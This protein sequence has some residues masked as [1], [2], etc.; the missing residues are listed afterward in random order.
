MTTTPR[1]LLATALTTAALAA[2]VDAPQTVPERSRY[3]ETSRAADVERFVD[4]CLALPHG[5]RLTVEK[6]RDLW[7]IETQ[8]AVDA[9]AR[10]G[11]P[12]AERSASAGE[13]DS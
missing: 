9:T 10:C 6:D 3:T 12:E 13:C 7:E 1:A 2:Q 11:E 8:V 4:A 5:D